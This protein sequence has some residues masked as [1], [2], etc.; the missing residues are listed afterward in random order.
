[1]TTSKKQLCRV[2]R[3]AIHKG[4]LICN[5]CKSRQDWRRHLTFSSTVLSLL[6]ALMSVSA[7]AIP[8]IASAF[9]SH[10]SDIRVAV[11]RTRE[12]DTV[13]NYLPDRKFDFQLYVANTGTRRGAIGR[14]QMRPTATNADSWED[15]DFTQHYAGTMDE[16]IEPGTATFLYYSRASLYT[17][18]TSGDRPLPDEIELKV[19]I[20][21]DDASRDHVSIDMATRSL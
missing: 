14:V 7:I 2:C 4:A 11:I 3:E 5:E 16:M 9:K 19:E 17:G 10:A 15:L 20:I 8:A 12:H 6:V 21:K 13:Q 1:M 18:G